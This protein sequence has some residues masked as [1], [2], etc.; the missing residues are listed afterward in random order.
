MLFGIIC[1]LAFD[2]SYFLEL[3]CCEYFHVLAFDDLDPGSSRQD[4]PLSVEL[5]DWKYAGSEPNGL[6]MFAPG[7]F[8]F[9]FC[10][11]LA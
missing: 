2:V 10:K 8:F 7:D 6:H 4:E 11:G 1:C 3:M 5:P 9:L